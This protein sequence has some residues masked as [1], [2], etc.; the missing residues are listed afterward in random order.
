MLLTSNQQHP[1]QTMISLTAIHKQAK[2]ICLALQ[3]M[4]GVPKSGENG[5]TEFW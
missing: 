1:P 3:R 2:R 5:V 4:Y